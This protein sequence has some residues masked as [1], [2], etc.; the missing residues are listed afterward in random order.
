MKPKELL[1]KVISLEIS[2]DDSVCFE[3]NE[4]TLNTPQFGF[5]MTPALP[6]TNWLK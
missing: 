2:S 5:F 1:L 4:T 6:L 3:R